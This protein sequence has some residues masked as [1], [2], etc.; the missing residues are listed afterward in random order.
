MLGEM[1]KA[2]PGPSPVDR[3]HRAS[4]PK[5][6]SDLGISHTQSSRW[7]KLA[8]IPEAD[9]AATF[10]KLRPLVYGPSPVT[11]PLPRRRNRRVASRT[12]RYRGY[13]IDIIAPTVR[14]AR[15]VAM[16]WAPNRRN[17]IVLPSDLSEVE[18]REAAEVVVDEMLD[19]LSRSQ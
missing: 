6:L 14:D 8:A 17:P 3:S 15:W 4:D 2:K 1:E 9:F 16:I 10:A 5:P 12:V 18:V 19:G 13:E 11:L 7:Q